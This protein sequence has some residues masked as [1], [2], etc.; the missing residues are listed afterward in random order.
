[1]KFEAFAQEYR[2]VEDGSGHLLPILRALRSLEVLSVC[3]ESTV[4]GISAV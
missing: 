1:M 3:Q 4:L 2:V